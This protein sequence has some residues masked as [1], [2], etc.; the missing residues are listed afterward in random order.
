[1][2]SHAATKGNRPTPR[3]SGSVARR[4]LEQRLHQVIK[5]V[6]DRGNR[7]PDCGLLVSYGTLCRGR[8]DV[9]SVGCEVVAAA[10]GPSTHKSGKCDPKSAPR[11]SHRRPARRPGSSDAVEFSP[12]GELPLVFLGVSYLT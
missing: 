12:F 1:K 7:L 10:R 5:L 4:R 9:R 6:H 8:A 2:G 3:C 11:P